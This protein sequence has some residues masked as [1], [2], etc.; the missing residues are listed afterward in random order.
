MNTIIKIEKN[1][2]NNKNMSNS[3]TKK[4]TNKIKS[5]FE[6]NKRNIVNNI[7]NFKNNVNS[8]NINNSHNTNFNSNDLKTKKSKTIF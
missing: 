5:K 6:I 1:K 7:T 8:V 2:L 3:N 4:L